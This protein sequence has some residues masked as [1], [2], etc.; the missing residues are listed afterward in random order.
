MA[1]GK[2]LKEARDARGE[3]QAEFCLRFGIDR[4]TYAGWETKGP[5][6]SGT[7]AVLIQRVLADLYPQEN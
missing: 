7:A 3:T 1:T 4:S 2:D 6:T 5:P